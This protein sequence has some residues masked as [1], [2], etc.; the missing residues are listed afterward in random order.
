MTQRLESGGRGTVVSFLLTLLSLTACTAPPV[1]RD[2]G[3]TTRLFA[4]AYQQVMD[5]YIEP[6]TARDVAMA[7]LSRLSALAPGIALSSDADGVVLRDGSTTLARLAAPDPT[8]ARRWGEITASVLD[9]ARAHWSSLAATSDERVEQSLFAGITGMLDRYSRYATPELAREQR[10]SREGFEGIGVSLDMSG[11]EVRISAVV[12][13]SPAD[14]ADIEVD[15]RII[16]IDGAPAAALSRQEVVSRLRGPVDS[17]VD[18]TLE[19]PGVPNRLNIALARAFIVVPTVTA[20]RDGEFAI[21]RLSGFNEH[22]TDS[23]RQSFV[24]LHKEMRGVL[25]G[26]ILDLRGNPGGLLNQGIAVA[27]LFMTGGRVAATVGRS[28]GSA[29]EFDAG[30]GD[31][32][33][34]IPMAVLINGGS[35]SSAE[36]VAAAL[37]DSGRAVIVGSS[38]YGKGTVQTVLPLP[39]DGELT[40]TWARLI[41]PAGYLLHEHGIVPAV[42]T[43]GA[44]GDK[45]AVAALLRRSGARESRGVA[46]SDLDET[47][48]TRLRHGCPGE[49]AERKIDL[50][51]AEKVLADPALYAHLVHP[52]PTAIAAKPTGASPQ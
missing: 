8:D 37:Q 26:I 10:A 19:R 41:T 36:I 5:Y 7:G 43:S 33:S 48:W 15:D 6:L 21:F 35:A 1:V 24:K 40:L 16:E 45:A 47:G 44:G 34:G 42:C 9:E 14:R 30:P 25:R 51:A 27:D 50:D 38:S 22:T 29:Q 4:R 11:D 18:L 28:P 12:A 13:G 52:Q 49:T 31:I 46:R 20:R 3:D 17:H 39:N 23:L 2:E 32:A